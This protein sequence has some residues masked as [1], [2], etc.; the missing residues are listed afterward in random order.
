MVRG[1]APLALRAVVFDLDDTLLPEWQYVRSAYGAVARHVYPDPEAAREAQGWL[2][3]RFLN[4]E[5]SGSLGALLER[6]GREEE[7]VGPLLEVYRSHS[8]A[9]RLSAGVQRTLRDLRGAGL[10]LGVVSDGPLVTQQ[11]KAEALNLAAWV[12]E[13]RLTDAWGREYWKPHARAYEDL[14]AA[15][16]LQEAE[17]AYVGDNLVKDFVAPNALGWRTVCLRR[18]RQV[19]AA[20]RAGPGGAPQVTVRSWTAL[21][22]LLR[23]WQ[24]DE[25]SGPDGAP[26]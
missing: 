17:L 4:G 12:D 15:W 8:P 14:Q 7:E 19:H 13:I 5:H 21:D 24:E 11:R 1:E 6:A 3:S 16:G 9:V 26:A 2:W 10:R 18:R 23:A 20:R 22:A 25:D